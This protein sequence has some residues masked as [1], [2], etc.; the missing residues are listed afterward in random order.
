MSKLA[1]SPLFIGLIFIL[2]TFMSSEGVNGIKCKVIPFT[3]ATCAQMCENHFGPDV[4]IRWWKYTDVG[5]FT[6]SEDTCTCCVDNQYLNEGLHTCALIPYNYID[7]NYTAEQTC[8]IRCQENLGE[9][10]PISAANYI[11]VSLNPLENNTCQC[12]RQDG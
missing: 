9:D 4:P 3:D 8:F 2:A 7:A 6:I 1:A 10:F 12:C 5:L 11:D